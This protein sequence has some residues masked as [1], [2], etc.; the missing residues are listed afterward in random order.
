MALRAE[1]CACRRAG[2]FARVVALAAQD[3]PPSP[4]VRT[5]PIHAMGRALV[6]LE[7]APPLR[8][9]SASRSLRN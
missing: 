8:S 6:T 1:M 3:A 2:T 5:G 7:S 4:P 9:A